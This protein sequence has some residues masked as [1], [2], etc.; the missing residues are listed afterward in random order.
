MTWRA[1]I[2]GDV[3]LRTDEN[4][5]DTVAC[6]DFAADVARDRRV[7]AVL[8]GGDIYEKASTPH[9]RA[10]FARAL[11]N[12]SCAPVFGVRGNHDAHEDVDLFN[13]FP[14]NTWAEQPAIV[15]VGPVDLLLVPW[16]DRA[17]LASAGY[18][19]E[20]G[21]RAGSAALAAMLR[22]MAAT[23]EHPDRPLVILGHLQVLGAQSSSAQPLIGKAIEAVLGDLQDLGAAAVVLG[24]IHKPQQVAPGIEYIGSLTCNNFGE[25]DE[26]KRI[27]ILTVEDDGTAGWEW[28]E[29]PC[30]R[31]VSV[32]M[33]VGENGPEEQVEGDPVWLFTG[34][35]APVMDHWGIADANVRVRYTCDESDQHLFDQEEIRRRF[36]AAHTLKVVPRVRHTERVRAAEV[37]EARTVRDKLIAWSAAT[38]ASLTEGIFAKLAE[39]EVEAVHG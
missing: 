20:E 6:L 35:Q 27:G 4:T 10:I 15:Q 38:G 33:R 11:Y 12:L 5:D 34:P 3:H 29:T 25:E 31:W 14:G 17:F 2:V 8:F 7:D 32:E 13:H 37:A 19:G 18:T 28:I 16:P 24:H 21:D 23:R 30:R 26:Q 9:E 1:L 22:G 39:L 36:A